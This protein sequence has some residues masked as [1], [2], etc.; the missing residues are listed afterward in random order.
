MMSK[1]KRNDL[2]LISICLVVAVF[3]LLIMNF[4]RK[5]GGYAT[6][7]VNGV[8]TAT[9]PLDKDVTVT[10]SNDQTSGYNLLVIEGGYASIVEANCPDKLCVRQK[11][12]KYNGQ[13]LVCLPNKTTVKIVSNSESDT[14]FIS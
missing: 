2:I 4:T 13:T 5:E 3:L 14:D 9:Y 7:V 6:V 8:E 1:L 11:K 10:L 12:I